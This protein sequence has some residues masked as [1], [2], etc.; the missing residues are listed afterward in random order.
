MFRCGRIE[1]PTPEEYIC[2]GQV[3]DQR[4]FWLEYQEADENVYDIREDKGQMEV[5]VK[6]F[7]TVSHNSL[8]SVE[9]NLQ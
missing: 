4:R 7:A 1:T 3:N 2:S 6:T 9:E 5:K 8:A